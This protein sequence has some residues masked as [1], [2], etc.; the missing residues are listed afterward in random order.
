[1]VK[2]SKK[3][4]QQTKESYN[5]IASHFSQKRQFLWPELKKIAQLVKNEDKVLDLGCGNGRLYQAFK[6]KKITYL[7]IDFSEELLKIAKKNYP[8]GKFLLA[9]IT[10]EKTYK[11]IGT[12][13]IC[14]CIAVLYHLP[15]PTLQL[16]VLKNVYQVLKE[17]GILVLSVWNLWNKNF[18]LLHLKQLGFKISSGFNFIQ[19]QKK[20]QRC[21]SGAKSELN[22]DEAIESSESVM[23]FDQIG[24][25]SY[26]SLRSFQDDKETNPKDTLLDLYKWLWIPYKISNGQKITR[27]IYRFCYSFG[28]RELEN[29]VVKAGF[30][31]RDSYYE[32]NGE[33]TNWLK[34]NNLFLIGKKW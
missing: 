31:I 17:E 18:W 23:R 7:G 5:L 34:G 24:P 14:F 11:K 21:H 12:F 32:S 28:Q 30:K 6:E 1:M 4:L 22:S 19:F 33:K 26:Q 9:D 20:K 8:Q 29:L 2:T 16:K 27:Q 25:R 10:E 13:D 3:I 15:S